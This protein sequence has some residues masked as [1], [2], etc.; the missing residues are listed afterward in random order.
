[1][2]E[3]SA[4][5]CDRTITWEIVDECVVIHDYQAGEP[6]NTVLPIAAFS[7]SVPSKCPHPRIVTDSRG[8]Y[9]TWCGAQD[10]TAP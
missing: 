10:V 5:Y 8:N 3:N 7:A 2:T 1:M 9:C 4:T 6:V